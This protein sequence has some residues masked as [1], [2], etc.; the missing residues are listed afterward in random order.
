[1]RKRFITRYQLPFPIFLLLTLLC[2][3]SNAQITELYTDYGGYWKSTAA[4]I[5]PVKPDNSHNV[6]GFKYAGTVYSTGVNDATLTSNGVAFTSMLFNALPF[7][8]VGGT[9]S[10]GTSTYIALGTQ[11]DGVTNGYGVPLPSLRILDVLTDGINGLNIGTGVTNVPVTSLFNYPVTN[12]NIAAIS[13]GR[14]DIVYTQTAQPTGSGDS[15]YFV[16][17][18]G[19][20]VGN[21]IYLV[22]TAVSSVGNYNCD[23]YNLTY[24]NGDAAVVSGGSSINQ[25]KEIRLYGLQMSDFGIT[26]GNAA[27]VTKLVIKPG[28][29][30]DPA[31]MGYNTDAFSVPLPVI[32]TQ[33][34]SQIVCPGAGLNATFSVTAT[35]SALSYQW[36]KNGVNI[37]GATA[38]TYTITNVTAADAGMYDVV[39]TNPAGSISGN[40]VY[41]NMTITTQ[42]SPATQTIVTGNSVTLSVASTN[43]TSFQWKRNNVNISGATAASYTI[44]PLTSNTGGDFTVT[45]INAAGAGCANLTSTMATGT[46]AVILYSKST[47]NLNVPVTWGVNSTG[48]G[49]SPVNFARSEHAFRVSNRTTAATGGNLTIAGVLDLV[50]SVTSITSASTLSAGQIVRNGTGTLAGSPSSSLTVNGVSDI[51]FFTGSQV[52]KN[53]TVTAGATT[54]NSL[55]EITAGASPGV[56]TINAGTFNTN[57][58]LTLRSDASGTASIGNSGGT[59][60]GNITVERYIPARRA[61]RLMTSPLNAPGAPTINAA[62]QE[63]AGL[64]DANPNPGYGTH[65]TGGTTANGFDQSPTNISSLKYF[66]GTS[67]VAIANTLS[68]PVTQY[69]GYM[70]FVRGNRAYDILTTVTSTTPFTTNIRSKGNVNQGTQAAKTV[71]ATGYTLLGN[72]YACPIDFNAVIAGSANVKNRFRVWDPTLGGTNGV[73]AYVLLDW[74]GSGYTVT[75]SASLNG[76]IQAGQ[77]FFTES[78]NGSLPGSFVVNESHKT[79]GTATTIFGRPAQADDAMLAIDLKIVNDDSTISLADGALAR[80]NDIYSNNIDGDDAV[81]FTNNNENISIV[82]N[83]QGLI[84]DKRTVP[85]EA[86]TLKLKFTG[87]KNINYQFEITTANFSAAN[88]LPLLYD[89]YLNTQQPVNIDGKTFHSFAVNQD[90]FSRAADR[91]GMIFRNLGILA[92]SF[93]N[94]K[95]YSPGEGSVIIEWKVQGVTDIQ[96]YEVQRQNSEGIFVT[97]GTLP[98]GSFSGSYAFTDVAACSGNNIYRVKSVDQG[99]AGKYSS[100]VKVFIAEKKSMLTVFPNPVTG[101]EFA[102]RFQHIPVGQYAYSVISSQGQ[103]VLTG[104]IQYQTTADYVVIGLDRKLA[105][106]N[107]ELLLQQGAGIYSTPI[108]IKRKM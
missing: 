17:S 107:Y 52:L 47:G 16:N 91:F 10:S 76:I 11:Y 77:A 41:L 79:T 20:V 43:A 65:I 66:T 9:V 106:G 71:A 19:A 3:V 105:D 12:V 13:D 40:I 89:K 74:N 2:T 96:S 6:L 78:S 29:D 14:P 87:I 60:N 36:R 4:S 99:V 67:W 22:W 101:N 54:L 70:F 1:M 50:N 18:S 104:T 97:I 92:V 73:G 33:P 24:T 5:N 8:S 45:V 48:T 63:G 35:G 80:Y 34:S 28:G 57:G 32:T 62:W 23:L 26:S 44:N 46:T 108:L 21:K 94:V 81:K 100:S 82:T 42:P 27:T 64:S 51:A 56:V 31:F 93:T 72:P 83:G 103:K 88:V 49:S 30:S 58:N 53:L 85:A 55:L 59:I 37:P 38:S 7:A 39:V 84:V 86:D 69:P 95:A 25:V 75:P 102:V 61:W 15:L 90:A 98:A 68:V